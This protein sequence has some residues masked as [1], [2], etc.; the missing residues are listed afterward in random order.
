MG[1]A[2][3]RVDWPPVGRVI[4]SRYPPI[5]LFEW[6]AEDPAVCD[7]LIA[8]VPQDLRVSAPRVG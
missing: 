1:M 3:C 5:N 8:L 2:T 7:A 6:L 4:A